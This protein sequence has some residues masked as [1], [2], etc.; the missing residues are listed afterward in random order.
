MGT[1]QTEVPV[2][3]SVEAFLQTMAVDFIGPTLARHACM[4]TPA[5]IIEALKVAGVDVLCMRLLAP[6]PSSEVA[7]SEVPH[8]TPGQRYSVRANPSIAD[9]AMA[10]LSF[11]IPTSVKTLFDE[12]VAELKDDELEPGITNQTDAGQDAIVKWLLLEG[13]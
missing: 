5:V 2:E 7:K 9:G 10:T 8:E 12:R 4:A 6:A 3:E 13:K 11:R 1:E